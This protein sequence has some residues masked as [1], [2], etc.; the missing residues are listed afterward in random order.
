MT[1]EERPTSSL[2]P[3]DCPIGERVLEATVVTATRLFGTRLVA[4][5]ALGSL[6]HGGFSVQVSDIDVGVILDDPLSP[7]DAAAIDVLKQRV[8]ELRL[9]LAD[10]L[11]VF[12]STPANLRRPS[13]EG[14]FPA[15]D[16]LDLLRH[17]RPLAGRDIRED[18]AVPTRE[19]LVI[20]AVRFALKILGAPDAIEE[21]CD[22]SRLASGGSRHV[23]KRVLFPVRFLYT[24]RTGEIGQ[25]EAAA[26]HYCSDG[27]PACRLVREAIRW[28]AD[29]PDEPGQ[30]IRLIA[31]HLRGLYVEFIDDHVARME[32]YQQGELAEALRTWRRD[33]LRAV[34]PQRP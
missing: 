5:Y 24:A 16:R 10:R 3:D 12:W 19:E 22:P 15:L 21:L 17:G 23:T 2:C 1:P 9:P 32:S 11:S 18:A 6:A 26:A 34:V 13:T 7:E 4:V 14:R 8:V 20:D 30:M 29:P 31:D 27:G 33:I 25:V 28:R